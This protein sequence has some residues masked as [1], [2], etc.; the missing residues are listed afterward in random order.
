MSRI[1]I[2]YEIMF[3]VIVSIS[4]TCLFTAI[5]EQ[6]YHILEL[7]GRLDNEEELFSSRIT[8]VIIWVF[9]LLNFLYMLMSRL[10]LL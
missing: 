7:Q 1:I 4:K 10:D 8:Y 9:I 5:R 6:S 2:A 3:I